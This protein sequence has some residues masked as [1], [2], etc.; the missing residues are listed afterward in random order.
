MLGSVLGEVWG[1][2]LM[3]LLPRV[4]IKVQIPAWT[5]SDTLF[6]MTKYPGQHVLVYN[7]THSIH[8]ILLSGY[9]YIFFI[10]SKKNLLS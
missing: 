1:P 9:I 6:K 4:F 5:Y 2:R 10:N 8:L 3:V 7:G